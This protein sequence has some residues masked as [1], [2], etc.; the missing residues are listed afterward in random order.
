MIDIL[1]GIVE[2]GD[3][4]GR[5]PG[6]PTTNLPIRGKFGLDGIWTACAGVEGLGGYAA[7]DA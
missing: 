2:H 1:H 7:T 4:R 3:A 5:E 6:F